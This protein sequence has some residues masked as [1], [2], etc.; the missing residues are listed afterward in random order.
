[1]GNSSVP[2]SVVLSPRKAVLAILLPLPLLHFLLI[3]GVQTHVV[4]QEQPATNAAM[5]IIGPG[6]GLVI[7]ATKPDVETEAVDGDGDN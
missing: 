7:T 3:A 5:V 1:M 4:P 2:R 6:S